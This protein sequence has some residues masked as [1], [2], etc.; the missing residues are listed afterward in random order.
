MKTRGGLTVRTNKL[1]NS[2]ALTRAAERCGLA[3][4]STQ[5][6][7]VS[8]IA[9][10]V[11]STGE[12]VP[13]GQSRW[14]ITIPWQQQELRVVWQEG[15]GLVTILP[16]DGEDRDVE[17]YSVSKSRLKSLLLRNAST[18]LKLTKRL[19]ELSPD[20]QSRAYLERCNYQLR[21]AIK[22]AELIA[23]EEY[24]ILEDLHSPEDRNA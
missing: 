3:L 24:E 18:A 11:F 16:R 19:T 6:V 1:N 12:R 23:T 20:E 2:H 4:N 14:E 10:R 15:Y 7:E 21:E 5:L 17:I 13:V 22:S 8:N 9:A